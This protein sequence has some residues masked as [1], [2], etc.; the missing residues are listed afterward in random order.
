MIISV[1]SMNYNYDVSRLF[2]CLCEEA[3][4]Q[5]GHIAGSGKAG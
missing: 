5:A 2:D 3:Q 4:K 1:E